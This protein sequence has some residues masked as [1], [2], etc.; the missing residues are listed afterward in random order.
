M[1]WEKG[2]YY[3]RST[4]VNGR[5]EREYFGCGEVAD[6]IATMDQLKREERKAKVQAVRQEFADAKALDETV[7][8]VCHVA[9]LFARAAMVA[10]GFHQ[11][12]RGEWRRRRVN[13]QK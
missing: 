3:T 13:T 7:S 2:R 11:H 8:Q 1:G 4:K 5:V 9:D 12:H 10:A 6:M